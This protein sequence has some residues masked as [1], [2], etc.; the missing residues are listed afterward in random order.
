LR[1][2]RNHYLRLDCSVLDPIYDPFF[3]LSRRL[4]CGRYASNELPLTTRGA[5]LSRLHSNEEPQQ[6]GQGEV[7]VWSMSMFFLHFKYS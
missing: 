6:V 7:N 3:H 2:Q 5:S 4:A 1:Y